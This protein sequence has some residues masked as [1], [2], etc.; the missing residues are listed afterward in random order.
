MAYCIHPE[1]ILNLENLISPH[2]S[3]FKQHLD[4]FFVYVKQI[5]T[6]FCCIFILQLTVDNLFLLS[7]NQFTMPTQP[8][9]MTISPTLAQLPALQRCLPSL[10]SAPVIYSFLPLT[11]DFQHHCTF[12]KEAYSR[13]LFPVPGVYPYSFIPTFLLIKPTTHRDFTLASSV[14]SCSD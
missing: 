6:L 11:E 9:N 3:N 7:F 8:E 2:L 13:F 5:K 1:H 12:L 4:F 14:S 10:C